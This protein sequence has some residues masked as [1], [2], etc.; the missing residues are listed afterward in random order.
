MLPTAL[1]HGAERTVALTFRCECPSLPPA[2]E[3]AA[4]GGAWGLALPLSF[5]QPVGLITTTVTVPGS[6]DETTVINNICGRAEATTLD[7]GL[8]IAVIS[9]ASPALRS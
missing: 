3:G 4:S 9:S 6:G 8:R 2:G 7:E 5:A 1:P